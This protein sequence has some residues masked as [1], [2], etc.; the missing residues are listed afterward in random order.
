M[1][2]S[3]NF[4]NLIQNCANYDLTSDILLLLLLCL[5][6]GKY[7]Y[8]WLDLVDTYGTIF[9]F[10]EFDTNCA[11]YDLTSDILLLLLLCILTGTSI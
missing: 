1:V 3:F 8:L 2:Q 4:L 7:R 9:Q 5:F 11:N 6:I 10:F